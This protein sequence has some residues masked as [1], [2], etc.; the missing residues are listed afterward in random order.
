MPL[1]CLA[2][3]KALEKAI[4]RVSQ[5][6]RRFQLVRSSGSGLFHL[7]KKAP[8]RWLT[9]PHP[10]NRLINTCS[11][12]KNSASA[13]H[14]T[15]SAPFIC[16]NG[17]DSILAEVGRCSVDRSD[18]ISQKWR[19][20]SPSDKLAFSVTTDKVKVERPIRRHPD[21]GRRIH[22]KLR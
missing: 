14:S 9:G 19:K 2:S 10:A 11:D 20:D 18:L 16:K 21:N 13:N 6:N 5:I 4:A 8:Q 1:H 22:N 15:D 3:S 7:P 17:I 12:R